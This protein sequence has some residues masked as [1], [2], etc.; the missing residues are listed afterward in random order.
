[1]AGGFGTMIPHFSNPD[2]NYPFFTFYPTGVAPPSCN[3]A[4]NALSING[5]SD[6]IANYRTACDTSDT[7][8]MASHDF[9]VGQGTDGTSRSASMSSNGQYMGFTSDATTFGGQ[10]G[11]SDIFLYN[12]ESTLVSLLSRHITQF[13]TGDSYSPAVSGNGRFVAFASD[14]FDLDAGGIDDTNNFADIYVW[15]Q[16]PPIPAQIRRVSLDSNENQ[17]VGGGSYSPSITHEGDLVAF[18]SDATNLVSDDGNG[19]RDIFVRDRTGGS[20][21]RVSLS[22]EPLEPDPDG[23]SY[24]PSISA[25]DGRY[26]AFE[27]EATNLLVGNDDNNARDIFVHDTDSGLTV[28]ASLSN[29]GMEANGPSYAAAISSDGT[30]VVFESNATNLLGDC[31]PG[32]SGDCNGF[33]DIF[34]RDIVEQETLR[35]S[36]G[37]NGEEADGPSYAPVISANLRYVAFH[38]DATNLLG[39][40]GDTNG[41]TDVFVRDLQE[42]T[43]FRV[44]IKSTGEQVTTAGCLAPAISFDGRFVA[45]DSDAT[46]LIPG[47]TN[48]LR[49]VFFRDRGVLLPGDFDGDYDV[50]DADLGILMGIW[51]PYTP[52]PSYIAVDLDPNC[53]IDADDLA[54]LLFNW[55]G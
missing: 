16:P 35:I 40:G 10:S 7:T 44:S 34:L 17:A 29:I 1:M 23:A 8:W 54:I 52:C 31:D 5:T 50:D 30:L 33:R 6:T 2:V 22:S 21:A 37:P 36:V 3:S 45:F 18:A 4:D 19:S 51:G 26:I 14:A 46:D 13:G 43:T 38:S 32:V 9:F 39:E 11:V 47:D 24:A 42:Q 25:D 20:T 41:L 49:D 12:R 28:R 15:E 55:T 53:D 27:S 48:G